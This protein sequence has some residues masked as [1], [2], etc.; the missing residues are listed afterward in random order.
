MT[1]RPQLDD[2]D[3]APDKTW[4]PTSSLWARRQAREATAAA[5]AAAR[6]KRTTRVTAGHADDAQEESE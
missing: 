3:P 6:T 5:V 2:R 1:A 4:T